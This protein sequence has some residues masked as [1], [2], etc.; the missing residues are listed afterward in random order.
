MHPFDPDFEDSPALCATCARVVSRLSAFPCHNCGFFVCERCLE[1]ARQCPR[2]L[3]GSIDDYTCCI[4]HDDAAAEDRQ[5]TP[6]R[7]E[8]NLVGGQQRRGT[9][10]VAE[11]DGEPI[12]HVL[13]GVGGGGDNENESDSSSA[14]DDWRE[15]NIYQAL[16]DFAP[17][18]AV[19]ECSTPVVEEL[20][21]EGEQSQ[22]TPRLDGGSERHGCDE[23]GVES[24]EHQDGYAVVVK[25]IL[26]SPGAMEGDSV[27][28]RD[29]NLEHT[30]QID[31]R[32]EESAR[33]PVEETSR[34]AKLRLH[35]ES[36]GK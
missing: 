10:S 2:C 28:E 21:K 1:K 22:E 8:T 33:P 13:E 24:T 11:A 32:V 26:K 9:Q 19:G 23:G 15:E 4:V 25:P 18:V 36:N 14:G 6:D 16:E 30:P 31:C 35:F 12:Y 17:P 34:I 29:L 27:E 20:E 5:H 7:V 3:M